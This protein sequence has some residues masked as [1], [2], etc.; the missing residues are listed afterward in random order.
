M[1][2]NS[3]V[4]LLFKSSGLNMED[5]QKAGRGCEILSDTRCVLLPLKPGFAH[6]VPMFQVL[7]PGLN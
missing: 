7:C 6:E 2:P 5:G 3:N 4:I 1:R